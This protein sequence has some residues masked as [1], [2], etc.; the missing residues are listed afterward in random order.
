MKDDEEFETLRLMY[1]V[2]NARSEHYEHQ[3]A[4]LTYVILTLAAALVA[5]ATFD[6]TLSPTDGWN[7]L[8]VTLLGA[9]GYTA[10]ILHGRRARRHGKRAEAYRNALDKRLPG[11]EINA[12][13][14]Q[15]PEENTLL[16]NLWD[17]IHIAIVVIGLLLAV[18]AWVVEMP[19]PP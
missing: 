1:Q 17:D 8:L 5:L 15:V 6:T 2:Q 9:F 10:S 18:L 3:R 4:T 12:I 19:P 13:R 7:G 11:A 14:R 16:D